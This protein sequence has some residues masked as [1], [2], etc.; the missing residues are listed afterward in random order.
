[1]Q[2]GSHMMRKVIHIP[3]GH[4]NDFAHHVAVAGTVDLDLYTSTCEGGGGE[5]AGGLWQRVEPVTSGA[6]G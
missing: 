5:N 2:K 6:K 1:M 3:R 4:M